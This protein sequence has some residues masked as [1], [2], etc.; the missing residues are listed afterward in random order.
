MD[1]KNHIKQ[2]AGELLPELI[3][4]RR[5][6]HENPELSFQEF[7]TGLGFENAAIGEY[8]CGSHH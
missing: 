7:E 2:R 6:I 8:G 1:I 5:H 3:R 4:V